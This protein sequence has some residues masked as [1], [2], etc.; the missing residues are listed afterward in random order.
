M[1]A[2]S[3]SRYG[4]VYAAWK[5][6]PAGFWGEQAKAIDW[7][8][9]PQTVFDPAQGAYGRWFVGGVCN[10][11]ATTRWTAMSRHPGPTKIAL[12]Y[13]SPVA[14]KIQ[15][16]ITYAR[17]A[18][19]GRDLRRGAAT[20]SAS[21]KGDRVIIYMPMV[22]EAA[23]AMLACAR[24][25]AMHSVVFGGFAPQRARH[26]HRR[27]PS[28]R[29][30]SPP[31]AASSPAAPS[32]PTSRCS[33]APSSWRRQ[34]RACV[35]FQRPQGPDARLVPA[36]TTTGPMLAHAN[37]RSAGL[38]AGGRDRPALRPLH[39]GHDRHSE[40]RGARLRRAHG[41][42][43]WSMQ[44]VYGI[45]PGDVFW[46]ASDV[47]WVVGH[48]YIVYAPLIARRDLDPVRGQAG[49]HAGCRRLL[50]GDRRAQGGGALFTAPTA[51]RAIKRD[52]P[53]RQAAQ[54]PRPVD[55]PHAVPGGR[56]LPIPT[57]CSGPS[58]SSKCRCIDHW[59]QT[60]TRLADRGNCV[61]L[62]ACCR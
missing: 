3:P 7:V 60:E 54:G 56:A 30:S 59:W 27:L 23:I 29:S 24:I 46:A 19:G 4:E 47:G 38:R 49:R 14:G 48:S 22:P 58:A 12:I 26:P 31:P 44:N 34:A 55:V 1:D 18:R 61:G 40:G 37:G 36:A 10:A 33:T 32:L 45:E 13:D 43:A 20:T 62:G 51:F 57:P 28:P 2:R 6:D 15:R 42:A 21:M 16:R 50:A 41:G 11:A 52:D 5:A 25:G 39:L 8:T 9:P 17:T 53:E 35:V